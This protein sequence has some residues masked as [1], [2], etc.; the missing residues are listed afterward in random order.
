MH[1]LVLSFVVCAFS[2]AAADT[3]PFTGT[4]RINLDK[5]QAPKKPTQWEIG[6]G[7]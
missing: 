4:W 3:M 7:R 5:M 1:R 6:N 2:L